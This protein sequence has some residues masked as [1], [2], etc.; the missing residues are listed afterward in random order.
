QR[1]IRRETGFI[2]DAVKQALIKGV[3]MLGTYLG[4]GKVIEQKLPGPP[5]KRILQVPCLCETPPAPT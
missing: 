2:L 1:S 3:H 4:Y 5:R